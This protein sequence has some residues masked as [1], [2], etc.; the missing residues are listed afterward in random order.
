LSPL[1][2]RRFDAVLRDS[3]EG[4]EIMGAGIADRRVGREHGW[5]EHRPVDGEKQ[6]TA[7]H[8]ERPYLYPNSSTV[9]PVSSPKWLM[10]S[11]L[12]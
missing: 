1:N 5:E 11:S 3:D 8:H 6:R 2:P 4:I 9:S 10:T 12:K 7:A